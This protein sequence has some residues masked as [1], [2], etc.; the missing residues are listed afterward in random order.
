MKKYKDWELLESL[1][2]GWVIDRTAGSPLCG[3]EFCTNGKSV[4]NGQKRALVFVGKTTQNNVESKPF[5]IADQKEKPIIDQVYVRTIND[6]ARKTFEQKMLSDIMVD[7]M[8]CEIE[9]WGKL[10]YIKSLRRSIAGLL[11]RTEI[12]ENSIQ[13][14]LFLTTDPTAC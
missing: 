13:T 12:K 9:G 4:L 6:L 1:P 8:I 14:N 10:D 5:I 2:N 11:R 7:L 3:Y